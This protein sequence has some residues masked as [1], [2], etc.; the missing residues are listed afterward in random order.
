MTTS[1]Y[2]LP[3]PAFFDPNGITQFDRYV[4][5]L[6]VEQEA[7]QMRRDHRVALAGADRRK[8]AFLAI[9]VQRTF[10]DPNG[11]L[12]VAGRSGTGAVDDSRRTAEFVYRNGRVIST[13]IP[14]LDTH[15]RAQIFHPAFW[16]DEAGHHPAPMTMISLD[17]LDAGRWLPNPAAAFSA[18]GNAGGIAYLN[19]YAR[20][21]VKQLSQD[22]KYALMVWPYH[23]LLGGNEFALV[24]SVHEAFFYHAAL[25]EASTAFEIKGG[26]PLTENYAVTHPEVLSDQRGVSIARRNTKFLETLLNHDLVIIAGQAKS[27]CVAWSIQG[28]LDEIGQTDPALAQKVYLVEDLTSSVVIPGV[29]DFTEQGDAAFERFR[30]AGMHVVRS[31]DPI[32]TWSSEAAA[33]IA[34]MLS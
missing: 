2:A 23:A 31:T 18:L 9:D 16:V 26:N 28:I 10:C 5:Y 33:V 17:D 7:L 14:T 13:I 15:R 21:Y 24:P 22:G 19:A 34:D 29:V 30:Q 8:I 27:H 6:Q 32:E 1:S 3:I 11:Q 20:H 12:F 25:R 4:P